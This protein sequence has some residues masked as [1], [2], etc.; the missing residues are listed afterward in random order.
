MIWFYGAHFW[1]YKYTACW[2]SAVQCSAVPMK[3]TGASMTSRA[4]LG[5][6]GTNI[7]AHS[8]GNR[9]SLNAV[10]IAVTNPDATQLNFNSEES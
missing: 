6:M 5:R 3:G 10:V 7:P 8:K 9:S 2:C 1:S 4:L